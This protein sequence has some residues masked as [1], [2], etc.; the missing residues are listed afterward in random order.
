MNPFRDLTYAQSIAYLAETFGP[1]DAVVFRNRRYT[2]VDVKHQ[3]DRASA[4][5]AS[6]GLA[7]GDKVA[8]LL[9]NRPEFLWYWLGASQMGLVA[10]MLN[11]RLRRDEL[12]YQLA[13][14]DSRAVVIPGDGAFRDFLA[15][16]AELAPALRGGAPGGL[17]SAELPALRHIVVMDPYDPAYTGALDWSAPATDDLPLP[18]METDGGKPGIIGYSSGTTAL[19]KGAMIDHCVWRKAWDTG[20][21]VDLTGD[22]CLYMTVPLFGSMATLNGVLPYLVRGAKQVI[23]EHFDAGHF[24]RSVEEERVTGL[25][26]LPPMIP[27]IIEHPDFK[28]RDHSSLRL[29]YT[30]SAD[31]AVLD[32]VADVIGIP[33]VMTGYGLTETTAVVSRNRW[34]D[35]REVRRTTQGYPLPDIEVRIVDPETLRDLPAGEIGE[36]WVRG[37]CTMLGYYKKPK[38]TADALLPDGWLRTGDAGLMTGDN[39]IRFQGRLGDGYKSRGFNVSPEEVEQAI[40]RH[41][42][43]ENSSVVGVPDPVADKIGAAFVIR[44]NGAQ[45]T[46]DELLDFLRPRLAGFKMPGHVFF[47]DEFPL[48]TGTGKVQK[49]KL[50]EMAAEHLGMPPPA[51]GPARK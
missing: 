39:R 50:R 33:G 3:V 51:S 29:A 10:V 22:D 26:L 4:R 36:I 48:T 21:R 41:P 45:V 19:P 7:P 6:L 20:I 23:G 24:L 2:F 1:R 46:A 43:V 34:D 17:G 14:S 49:F 11:T 5:Y 18:A 13:Q 32:T 31:P 8:I 42:A 38:E 35:P 47:V 12:A 40:N 44:R 30:L 25:H 37:Y 28:T 15:E 27:S 16:L 9:P